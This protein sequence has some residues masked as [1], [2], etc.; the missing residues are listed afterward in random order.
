MAVFLLFAGVAYAMFADK[1]VPVKGEASY[2]ACGCGCGGGV[3]PKVECVG[4]QSELERII[5]EDKL[6]SQSKSCPMMG[7]SLGK[8]YTV[9]D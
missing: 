5:A 8:R 6:A 3:Q 4:S 7:C 1:P 2:T 9:C